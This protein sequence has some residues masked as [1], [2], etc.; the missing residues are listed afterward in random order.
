MTVQEQYPDNKLAWITVFMLSLAYMLSVM[1]R[2]ILILLVEPLRQDLGISD[3]EVSL[4]TGFAFAIVYTLAGIPMGV[5]ADR[6]VRKYVILIGVSIWGAMTIA[7]GFA[8]NFAQLFIFRMGVGFGEASLTPS[9]YAMIPDLFPPRKMAFAVS[10]FALTGLVGGSLSLLVGGVIISASGSLTSIS[11][12]ILGVMPAWRIVL[13]MAGL[14]TLAVVGLLMFMKEPVRKT[15]VAAP[16]MDDGS[17]KPV[18]FRRVLSEFKM[19][20][21]FYLPFIA[22]CSVA[23]IFVFGGQIWLPTYF[24]RIHGWS[25]GE[26]GM[27]LGLITLLPMLLGG[28]LSGKIADRYFAKGVHGISLISMMAAFGG[29]IL[30]LLVIIFVP[31]MPIKLGALALYYFLFAYAIVLFPT[32]VQLSANPQMRA[33]TSAIIL[34]IINIIGAGLG[35]TV[36]ALI[37]D[38]VFQDSNAVG[39]SI[40]LSGAVCNSLAAILLFV[41]FKPF[42]QRLKTLGVSAG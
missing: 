24:V 26:T 27:I 39:S 5:L 31:L 37:T 34:F 29:N 13:I 7:C 22:A 17:T 16:T 1:D 33:Q 15:P 41:A 23:N 38:Y 36:I 32:A 10:V 20:W 12:P 2:M 35:A 19:D 8:K 18:S 28:V 42:L 40:A 11:W 21:T 14:I 6:W 3:T 30:L 25:E 4:L 9:A